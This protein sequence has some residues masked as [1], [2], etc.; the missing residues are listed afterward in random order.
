MYPPSLKGPC[1][2]IRHP[3]GVSL[4]TL[5]LTK[6]VPIVSVE[7]LTNVT[8]S[9]PHGNVSVWSERVSVTGASAGRSRTN[10]VS[11]VS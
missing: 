2:T 1:V 11:A 9:F 5:Q 10:I 6:L 7:S 4:R 8:V 3:S